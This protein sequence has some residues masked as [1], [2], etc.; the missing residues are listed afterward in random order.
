M[1]ILHVYKD[2]FP[3]LGGIENYIR[4]LAEAQVRRG[5]TVTV[6]VTNRGRRT[7]EENLN[8][9]RVL[10][11]G[12]LATVAS[13][14]LSL[15]LPRLLARE[16]P[17]ITHLH[18]PYPVGEI[19]QWLVGHNR[20]YV[21]TYHADPTRLAQRAMMFFYTPLLRLILRRARGVLATSPNYAATSPH[22]RRVPERTVIVPIGVDA[23][24]FTPATRDAETSL[25]SGAP[26]VLSDSRRMAGR[27]RRTGLSM[28][29]SREILTILSVGQM[30]HYKGVDDLLRTLPHLP[31]SARLVLAG[32]GPKR[33]EWE[34]LSRQ[35]ELGERV[36]FLGDVPDASLPALYQSADIYVLPANTRAEAFG[37]ALLEAMASGLP[38]VTTEVGS[39]TSYV[40]ENEVTGLVTPP[41]SPEALAQAL[42]RL[43]ADS[44]LRSRMGAAG[45]ERVL[46]HFTLEKMIERVEEAYERMKS[47]G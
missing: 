23:Q 18:F 31:D 10:K 38:C 41:H 20:P 40:V 7:V 43:I 39:G 37:I 32:D 13:A 11:A 25:L 42:T 45:R 3:V 29:N 30:R 14:P 33:A 35:L 21:I 17:D 24:R 9:V 2:Y 1:N 16:A 34:A 12:R 19:S 4:W 15:E 46:Q 36:T 26:H 27:S 8:G 5:H 6:L 28:T 22:L 44:A 47:E